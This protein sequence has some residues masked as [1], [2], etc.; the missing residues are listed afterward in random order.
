MKREILLAT[1]FLAFMG[2]SLPQASADQTITFDD[3]S[4]GAHPGPDHYAAQGVV[5]PGSAL[6]NR[7]SR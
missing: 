6:A 4:P 5:F 7:S 3:L 1:F 2:L